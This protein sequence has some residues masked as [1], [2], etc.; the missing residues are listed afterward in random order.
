MGKCLNAVWAY[1]WMVWLYGITSY[2][3]M[4]V[5][6]KIL[7]EGMVKKSVWLEVQL[8]DMCGLETKYCVFHNVGE[9]AVVW[10]VYCSVYSS[11][12]WVCK[13]STVWIMWYTLYPLV[14]QCSWFHMIKYLTKCD[15]ILWQLLCTESELRDVPFSWPKWCKIF[16]MSASALLSDSTGTAQLTCLLE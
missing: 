10:S 6:W 15:T 3:T 2:I 11:I 4:F 5:L 12:V 7:Y 9:D 16:A 14:L 1:Y 8:S 13:Y